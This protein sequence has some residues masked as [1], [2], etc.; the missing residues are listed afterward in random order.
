M[1]FNPAQNPLLNDFQGGQMT[2]LPL[3]P[4]GTV[5]L[6]ALF[7]VVSPGNQA[8]GVN[9]AIT[10]ANLALLIAGALYLTPTFV[11]SGASYSS[12]RTDTRILVNKT[13]GSATSI[14][15]GDATLYSLPVLVKDLK[16]DA[17][18]HPITVT[19]TGGQRLDGL[20]QIVIN[21]PFGYFWFNPLASS[22]WY[23]AAY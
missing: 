23:D 20:S 16:G 17:D 19:F 7:E 10:A 13:I 3:F 11:T 15:L 9:Y 1:V 12:V 5:D 14:V 6:T 4:G 18:S 8:N 21:N 2:D 22:A